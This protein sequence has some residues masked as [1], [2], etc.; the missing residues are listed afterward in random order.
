MR[1]LDIYTLINYLNYSL[2]DANLIYTYSNLLTNNNR[3]K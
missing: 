1:E 3:P 2:I